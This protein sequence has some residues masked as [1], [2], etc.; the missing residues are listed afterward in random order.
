M[1][2]NLVN[3]KEYKKAL[4]VYKE[5][6]EVLLILNEFIDKLKPYGKYNAVGIVIK[7]AFHQK[8]TLEGNLVTVKQI[9]D[10][11]GKIINEP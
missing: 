8:K 9:I 2:V 4:I 3:F 1:S 10:K 6:Q 11:K 5:V 7:A